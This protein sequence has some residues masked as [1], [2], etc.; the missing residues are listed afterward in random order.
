MPRR[1]RKRQEPVEA[2]AR[3]ALGYPIQRPS[4]DARIVTVRRRHLV[5]DFS[6]ASDDDAKASTVEFDRTV[7]GS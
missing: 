5:Q 4:P 7:D 3:D 2:P 6:R 1:E